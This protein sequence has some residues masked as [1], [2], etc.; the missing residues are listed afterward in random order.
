[1]GQTEQFHIRSIPEL[2]ELFDQHSPVKHP[3]I[4]LIDFS[5]F[6]HGPHAA[7]RVQFDLYGIIHS[8][9]CADVIAYGQTDHDFDNGT[10]LFAKP[11][12]VWEAEALDAP[13]QKDGWALYFHPDLL[14]NSKLADTLHT[15]SFFDYSVREAL[16]LSDRE[17]QTL[18][19]LAW[20]IE[21]EISQNLDKHSRELVVGNL[22]L[23]LKYSNRFYDR[24]FITRETSNNVIVRRFAQ[25]LK[26]YIGSGRLRKDGLVSVQ[27]SAEHL[28]ISPNYLS[29]LLKKETGKNATEHIHLAVVEQAKKKLQHTAGSIKEIAYELGFEYA[30]SFSKMFKNATGLTPSVYRT[31]N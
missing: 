24:Q 16:H 7:R 4:S 28:Q 12:Q 31:L 10:M 5:S 18:T 1:M 8:N 14:L 26:E 9:K 25:F 2:H 21:E 19:Q 20:T 6:V 23:I 30:S 11:G 29:D 22:E 13:V 3:L 27:Q 15:Y 17:K